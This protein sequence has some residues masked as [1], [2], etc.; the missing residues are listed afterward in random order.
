MTEAGVPKI[1]TSGEGGGTTGGGRAGGMHR[2]KLARAVTLVEY[3]PG[4]SVFDTKTKLVKFNGN[5][6]LTSE[7]T[8]ENA[9]LNK[10]R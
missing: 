8:N 3:H 7:A 2:V 1:D 6:I 10:M 9:I 5:G 4:L